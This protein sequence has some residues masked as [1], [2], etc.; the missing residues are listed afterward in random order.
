VV[1]KERRVLMVGELFSFRRW[2][3][4]TWTGLEGSRDRAFLPSYRG[5]VNQISLQAGAASSSVNS[6]VV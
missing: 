3:S 5:H 4:A 1:A 6:T 2:G